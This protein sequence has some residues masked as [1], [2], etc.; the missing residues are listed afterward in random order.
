M[1][2]TRVSNAVGN[3]C[4]NQ[5]LLALDSG[6]GPG[7]LQVYDGVF[8]SS[9]D[10]AITTQTLLATMILAHPCGF[11]TDKVLTFYPVTTGIS[12]AAGV[13]RFGRLLTSNMVA[14]LD[15]NASGI[16]GGG[17]LILTSTAI[18]LGGP[19]RVE[20]LYVVIG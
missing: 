3:A 5:I 18:P 4:A 14:C 20:S 15:V 2:I 9:P 19:V 11:L 16:G 7:F 1:P 6:G 8:P 13:A 10:V 17:G 12:V